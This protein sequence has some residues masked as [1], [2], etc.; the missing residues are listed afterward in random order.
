MALIFVD[1][2]TTGLDPQHDL[3][4]EVA[5]VVTDDKLSVLNGMSRLVSWNAE[6]V[7]QRMDDY[8]TEMHTK[9]GL[10]KALAGPHTYRLSTLDTAFATFVEVNSDGAKLPMVGNSVHFDRSFIAAHMPKTHAQFHYRNIDLS[11][12]REAA[13]L[14]NPES[15][16]SIPTDHKAH[17]ATDD[18]HDSIALA[19]WAM[20]LIQ[21]EMPV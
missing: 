7:E 9:S 10:I 6:L 1:I 12:F 2:E 18:V 8:V 14:W 11:G 16:E 3:I 15:L 20:A 4:L 13:K 19:G 5:M 17:R 21:G